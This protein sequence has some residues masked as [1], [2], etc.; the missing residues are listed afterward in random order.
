MGKDRID[1]LLREN[2]CLGKIG[3]F[4]IIY[5]KVGK[6]FS[7][8]DSLSMRINVTRCL[9]LYPGGNSVSGVVCAP[10]VNWITSL[11][12][13]WF[14]RAA[15]LKCNVGLIIPQCLVTTSHH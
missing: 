13:Y 6:L 10:S 2:L 15:S 1:S 11:L 7:L 8:M 5:T 9:V 4:L 3:S 14:I 12:C